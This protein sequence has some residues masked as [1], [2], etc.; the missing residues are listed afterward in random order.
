MSLIK[1]WCVLYS[2]C[3]QLVLELL[4][5][6]TCHVPRCS[7]SGTFDHGML[8]KDILIHPCGTM[9]NTGLPSPGMGGFSGGCD[10]HFNQAQQQQQQ[11][12]QQHAMSQAQIKMLK[13]HNL[14]LNQQLATQA[15]SHIQH[16]Q[17][18]MPFQPSVTPPSSAN[19]SPAAPVPG[20]PKSEPTSHPV[21]LDT[22]EV[23]EKLRDE[24]KENLSSTIR[25]FRLSTSKKWPP[26]HINLLRQHHHFHVHFHFQHPYL[27]HPIYPRTLLIRPFQ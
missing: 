12:Q 4:H 3:I 7:P 13:Q 25:N 21:N 6:Y 24:I 2:G 14:L 20:P 27:I 22:D 17:Q 16:L 15:Q 19:V 18:T 9:A 1:K 23:V 26:R 11:Q 8:L 5:P 10:P